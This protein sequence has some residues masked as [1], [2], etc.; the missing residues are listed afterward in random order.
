[1]D[2]LLKLLISPILSGLF[3][4]LGGVIGVRWTFQ[5]ALKLKQQDFDNTLKQKEVELNNSR[6][7]NQDGLIF[8]ERFKAI[9]RMIDAG[10]EATLSLLDLVSSLTSF[11]SLDEQ[12]SVKLEKSRAFSAELDRKLIEF[13]STSR[14]LR[15]TDKIADEKFNELWRRLNNTKGYADMFISE[16][17]GG[18]FTNQDERWDAIRH[19][20]GLYQGQRLKGSDSTNAS[21]KFSDEDFRTYLDGILKSGSTTA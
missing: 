21:V 9:D 8:S 18:K 7:Q 16:M 3:G 20:S 6:L 19:V 4:L 11:F 12:T 2:D 5:N 15:F 14:Y 17:E 10:S 13:R 1:M